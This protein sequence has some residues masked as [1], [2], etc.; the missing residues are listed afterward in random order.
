MREQFTI[1]KNYIQGAN[2]LKC[3]HFWQQKKRHSA[4][5]ILTLRQ[6]YLI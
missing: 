3:Y 5:Y 1:L 6:L 2:H 4:N